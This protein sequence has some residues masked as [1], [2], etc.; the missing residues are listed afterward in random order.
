MK[1]VHKIAA[2]SSALLL[3]TVSLLNTTQY[4]NVKTE[5]TKTIEESIT[6]IVQGVTE[7][8]ASELNGKKAVAN[9]ATSLINNDPSYEYITEVITQKPIKDAFLLTRNIDNGFFMVLEPLLYAL[10]RMQSSHKQHQRPGTSCVNKG[11]CS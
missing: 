9:Y 2:A 8:V 1:F 4:F 7:T 5:L 10:L 6:D 11:E 3:I